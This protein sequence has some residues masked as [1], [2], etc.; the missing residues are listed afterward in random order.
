MLRHFRHSSRLGACLHGSVAPRSSLSCVRAQ[1]AT[2]VPSPNLYISNSLQTQAGPCSVPLQPAIAHPCVH[3]HSRALRRAA[4]SAR[5]NSGVCFSTAVADAPN[6]TG[7]DVEYE[8][9]IGIETHVQLLTK[10]KAFCSCP[11]KFGSEPNTNVCPVCLGHPGT[12]PSLNAAAVDLGVRASLALGGAVARTSKFDRKQYFYADLP[13]G[14]QISQYDEPLCS[15]GAVEVEEKDGTRKRYGITRAHLEEDSGKTV[16]GGADRMA[17]SEY[18]LVDFNRAGV[19]LLEIVSEPDMRSGRDAYQY[20]D[21]LRRI[22]RFTGVSDGNMAE[23]SMR[24]DVNVSVRPK[25]AS[26]FG[27]KVEIKNMNSFS[28]MQKAIDFEIERQSNLLRAGRGSEIVLE[29]RLWDEFKLQTYSMRKKEGLADY[30]YFPEPDLPPLVLSEEMLEQIKASMPELPAARRARYLSLGLP[31]QDVLVLAD[32]PTIATFFDTVLATNVNP[33][34]AAN[35]ITGDIQAY[36]KDNKKGMG[37]LAMT[38]QVLA[39]MVALIEEGVISGKI[40]KDL[41]PSLLEGA[42]NEKGV[43]QLV[44]EKGM[45]MVTDEGQIAAMVEQILAANPKQLE[46]YRGGKN[47][48]QSF[49]EGQVMKESKGRVDPKLM[50]AVLMKKLNQEA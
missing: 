23:G 3:T 49:F 21:E 36:C 20:G 33:K 50:K 42:A 22:L 46:Q 10:T 31:L 39:D 25:G 11:S 5:Q 4:S 29:T 9:V 7:Q 44:T 27:T 30:R 45:T 38:P 6:A 1:P 40:A 32:E 12:L 2:P 48:L 47:K 8:A 34:A 18:S 14:Y 17:G 24:C 43:R 15:G 35:W 37:E 16:Y 19:P 41:L 26:E 13:K 28:N